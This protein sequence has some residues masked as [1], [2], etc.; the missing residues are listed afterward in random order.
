MEKNKYSILAFTLMLTATIAFSSCSSSGVNESGEAPAEELPV[1]DAETDQLPPA[2]DGSGEAT[3]DPTSGAIDGTAVTQDPSSLP[4]EGMPPVADTSAPP[5]MDSSMPPVDSNN[6]TV[7][8]LAPEQSASEPVATEYTGPLSGSDSSLGSPS[9]SESTSSG[10]NPSGSYT[11]K[12]GDTLMKIAYKVY[13]DIF[14][15]KEILDANR[16]SISDVKM[17][18][19][20]STL[21]VDGDA[22]DMNFEGYE[23]YAI[24]GGDTLGSISQDIYGTKKRWKKLWQ[25]NDK[26]IKDPNRIYAG[27]YLRYTFTA[28]D[29]AQKDQNLQNSGGAPLGQNGGM[30]TEERN[31][32]S[33]GGAPTITSEPLMNPQGQ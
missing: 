27:F 5:S 31:P 3:V 18:R 17:L 20:G 1:V 23:R 13:G 26:L 12:R 21:K 10:S 2:V 15:W 28:E 8:G 19:T 16:D 9:S 24:K 33:V 25:M 32:S 4:P 30:G 11:V 7:A 22:Q 6:G 14:R 29:S